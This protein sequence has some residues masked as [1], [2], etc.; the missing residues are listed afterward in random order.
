MGHRSQ[1]Q[2]AA[3]DVY[4]GILPSLSLGVSAPE[5]KGLPL[6]ISEEPCPPVSYR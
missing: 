3:I 2:T 4:R 1:Q 5:R 6:D